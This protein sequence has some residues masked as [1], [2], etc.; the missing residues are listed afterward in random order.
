MIKYID[1]EWLKDLYKPYEGYSVPVG[2]ILA[3]I[4]DAPSIGI[5]RCEDC[6]YWV[7]DGEPYPFCEISELHKKADDFCSDGKE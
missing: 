4:D 5:V 7:K 1:A 2:V 3:N 6:Q